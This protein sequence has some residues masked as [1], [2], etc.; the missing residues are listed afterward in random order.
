MTADG[1]S[2]Q[3][4]GI[5]TTRGRPDPQSNR[6][7]SSSGLRAAG[8]ILVRVGSCASWFTLMATPMVGSS[9]VRVID[10]AHILPE[11]GMQMQGQMHVHL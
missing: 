4:A 11:L 2:H 9:V 8:S 3:S 7:G 6:G 10:A 5:R 1:E